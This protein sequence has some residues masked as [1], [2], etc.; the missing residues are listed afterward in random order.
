MCRN[1]AHEW[2]C[3]HTCPQGAT[4]RCLSISP[5]KGASAYVPERLSAESVAERSLSQ[6]SLRTSFTCS[7][8][9]LALTCWAW[10]HVYQASAVDLLFPLQQHSRWLWFPVLPRLASAFTYLLCFPSSSPCLSSLTAFFINSIT[11]RL[12]DFQDPASSVWDVTHSF[13]ETNTRNVHEQSICAKLYIHRYFLGDHY[14]CTL[15]G[16]VDGCVV[17]WTELELIWPHVH[18]PCARSTFE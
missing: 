2:A 10:S 13:S 15:K 8:C 11:E 6:A 16:Q 3:V 12:T 4:R 17:L 9:F 18:T 1:A 5:L 14:R 7:D